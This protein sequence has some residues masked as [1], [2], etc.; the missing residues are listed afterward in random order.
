MNRDLI[1]EGDKVILTSFKPEHAGTL[2]KWR[3]RT[4]VIQY[5][6]NPN[7]L[8][9]EDHLNWFNNFYLLDD[10]RIDFVITDKASGIE[11]GTCGIKNIAS[12]NVEL[13]YAIGE[14][15]MRGKG[16]AAEAV[17]IL[18]DFA[19]REY[20]AECAVACVHE[21]NAASRGFIKRLG[22]TSDNARLEENPK[23][24]IFKK[25]L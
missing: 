3:N 15:D 1:I 23:F 6:L 9:M 25:E 13:S 18:M 10:D 14:S 2:V 7:P 4:D 17:M 19:E 21:E 5:F 8:K 12:K 20:G 24:I 22:F 16:L 11:A